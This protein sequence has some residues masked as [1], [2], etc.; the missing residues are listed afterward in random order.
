MTRVETAPSP[1]TTVRRHPERGVYDRAAIDAILDEA[2]CCHVGFVNDGRPFVIPTIHTRAGDTLY[3]HGSPASRMLR[4]LGGGIDVCVTV[5]I[6]DGLV[7]ARSVYNH[8]MNYRSV[9]VLGSARPV[10]ERAEKL[11]ALEAIVE[12]VAAGRSADARPPSDK[13]LAG[14]TVLAISLDEASAKVRSGPP[15]DFDE[16]VSLPIWAGVVPLEL[17]AGPPESARDLP[18]GLTVPGYA[19]EYRRP[20]ARR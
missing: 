16:D 14:T 1:R 8:S 3:L 4:T 12:H 19:R 15:K 13:E 2:L 20:D 10:E 18:A 5:T 7:L 11:A 9:V 6:L 17:A